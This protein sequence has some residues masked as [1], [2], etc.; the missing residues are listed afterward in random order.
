MPKI[1]K[2][3]I[4][5][6]VG[7]AGIRKFFSYTSNFAKLLEGCYTHKYHEDGGD[8]EVYIMY[9]STLYLKDM[10]TGEDVAVGIKELLEDITEIHEH[11][12]NFI[13]LDT[14]YI[15]NRR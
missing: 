12:K 6:S 14:L 2:L 3:H 10:T 13:V 15:Y 9:W 5:D 4:M 1:I 7:E 11:S 8:T